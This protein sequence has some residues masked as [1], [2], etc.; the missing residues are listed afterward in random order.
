M[1]FHQQNRPTAEDLSF[2]SFS[3][4]TPRRDVQFTP[5]Q[6]LGPTGAY[7]E[8]EKLS[9]RTQRE[10]LQEMMPVCCFH[11]ASEPGT[12]GLTGFPTN[13]CRTHPGAETQHAC[14]KDCSFLLQVVLCLLQSTW[15]WPLSS[16]FFLSSLLPMV[17]ILCVGPKC[18]HTCPYKSD[19]QRRRQYE[20]RGRGLEVRPP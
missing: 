1:R 17:G 9:R 13:P 3:N 6:M 10:R 12:S 14:F 8:K 15:L 16:L 5:T 19:T 4:S 11:V 2:S 18:Y 7:G 20:D